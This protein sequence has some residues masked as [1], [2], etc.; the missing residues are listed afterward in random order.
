MPPC[1]EP[2]VRSRFFVSEFLANGPH[3]GYCC[4]YA[5]QVLAL[6][7]VSAVMLSKLAIDIAILTDGTDECFTGL[8]VEHI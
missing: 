7:G 8:T 5:L 1:I 3:R 6:L 2:L 4:A